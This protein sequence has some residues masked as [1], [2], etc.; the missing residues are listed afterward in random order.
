M[1]VNGDG[2]CVRTPA[3]ITDLWLTRDLHLCQLCPV[4]TLE[5]PTQTVCQQAV[6]ERLF[7]F[8]PTAVTQPAAVGVHNWK[9][10][11]HDCGTNR[12]VSRWTLIVFTFSHDVTWS[13]TVFFTTSLVSCII[14]LLICETS[15]LFVYFP[16]LKSVSWHGLEMGLHQYNWLDLLTVLISN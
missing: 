16:S 1:A 5:K 9:H 2:W 12:Q 10:R 3:A 15:I 7:L 13:R 6:Q 4:W 14:Q 11:V 8:P